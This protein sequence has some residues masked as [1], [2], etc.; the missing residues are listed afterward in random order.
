MPASFVAY[1]DEAGDEGFKFL[2][3]EAG[4]S[5]W[6]VLSAVVFRHSGTLAP[7]QALAEVR[8]TLNVEA[9]KPI[10]FRDLKHEKRVVCTSIIAKYPFRTVTVASYKPD[11]DDPEHYR[12]NKDLLY[13]YLTRLLLERVS[14]LCRD[15]KKPEEGDGCVDL[16]FSDRAAMSY[17]DMRA[18]LRHLQAQMDGSVRIHWPAIKTENIR[19]VQHAKLAGLQVADAVASSTFFA[20]HLNPYGHAEPR[21]ANI[22]KGHV[23][24]HKQSRL[25]YGLKFLSNFESLKSRMPHVGAAFGDW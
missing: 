10:H 24:R 8:T 17:E 2:P 7:V 4:S 16:V 25:G 9:K 11:I 5:R 22:L 6:F 18:Y 20:L 12:S 13:R 14:W 21:Y 23:Y 19:A 3:N 15:N 1:I